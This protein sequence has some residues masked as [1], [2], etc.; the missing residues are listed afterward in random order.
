MRKPLQQGLFVLFGVNWAAEKARIYLFAHLSAKKYAHP[1]CKIYLGCAFL[2]WGICASILVQIN[3]GVRTESKHKSAISFFAFKSKALK[4]VM[5]GF[6]QGQNDLRS[7][8][9]SRQTRSPV[10]TCFGSR[11]MHRLPRWPGAGSLIRR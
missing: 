11:H 1:G 4:V 3:D 5:P 8:P 2:V 9:Y 6:R 7:S 10:K